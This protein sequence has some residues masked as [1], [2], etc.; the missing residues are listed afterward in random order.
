MNTLNRIASKAG[1]VLLACALLQAGCFYLGQDRFE[2][3]VQHPPS[4]WSSRDCLT[5]ILAAMVSNVGTN[6]SKLEVIATPFLPS[7][8]AA[9]NQIQRVQH[10][11]SDQ[12]AQYHMDELLRGS[13]GLFVDWSN[14][15]F[16]NAKGNYFTDQ[17]DLDSLLVVVTLK[18]KT[19]PCAVAAT[20]TS[21]SPHGMTPRTSS[22]SCGR[23]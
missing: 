17:T 19:W 20:T 2:S 22:P 3:I 21:L 5:I 9:L 15:K 16:V 11:W 13:S 8:V 14:G 6:E 12:D 7:V 23:A 10:H 4:E 18:N 1:A